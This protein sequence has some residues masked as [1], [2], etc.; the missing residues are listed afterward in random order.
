M[1]GAKSVKAKTALRVLMI[2][3]EAHPFSKTG[4]LADVASALPKALGRLGHEVTLVTPRYRGIDVAAVSASVRLGMAGVEFEAGMIELPL[5][6]GARAV[7]VDC[8]PLYD[9]PGIYGEGGVD[10]PDNALR[11]AF[12]TAA[13]L[14]W[15][16]QQPQ[17]FHIVH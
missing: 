2:A 7:F 6:P 16:A 4:G 10:Y 14:D 3:S 11:Y 12:L 17:P 5:G 8:P 13:A 9:R 1:R 15:A